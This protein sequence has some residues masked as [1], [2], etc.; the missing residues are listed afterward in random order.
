[1]ISARD[2]PMAVSARYPNSFSAAGFHDVIIPPLST[3]TIASSAAA[4]AY[5]NSRDAPNDVG[6][7]CWST[8]DLI[9]SW[10]LVGDDWQLVD[11][12]GAMRPAAPPHRRGQAEIR[13]GQGIRHQP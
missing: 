1:M 7:L 2:C 8:E 13:A 5:C 12:T 9:A 4:G 6:S 10:T 11:K 3:V